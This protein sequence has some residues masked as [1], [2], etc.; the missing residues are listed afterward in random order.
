MGFLIL[1]MW[2]FVEPL[3]LVVF[4]TTPGRWLLRTKLAAPGSEITYGKALARS[5]KVWWRG[6]AMG[7]PFVSFFTLLHAYRKL[8]R[9]G[10][11]S[12]DLEGGFVVEHSPVGI[13]RTVAVIVLSL[14]CLMF[15]GA[16]SA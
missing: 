15:I 12:W 16:A 10:T 8:G 3:C 11:T 4:K 9:T 6:M 13:G 2:V 5:L 1:L 14:V 7:V